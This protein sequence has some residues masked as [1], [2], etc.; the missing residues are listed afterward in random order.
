MTQPRGCRIFLQDCMKHGCFIQA[1]RD[2]FTACPEGRYGID[3]AAL[4]DPLRLTKQLPQPAGENRQVITQGITDH[5]HQ[6]GGRDQRFAMMRRDD[7]R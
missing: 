5:R 2:G 3:L 1:P 6:D 7:G 4:A